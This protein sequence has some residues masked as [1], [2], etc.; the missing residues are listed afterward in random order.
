[1]ACLKL[2]IIPNWQANIHKTVYG[3]G[4][5]QVCYAPL[6]LKR[7]RRER[8]HTEATYYDRLMQLD[9]SWHSL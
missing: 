7:A 8:L 6:N 5:G 2:I 3:A 1:M 4:K 9:L